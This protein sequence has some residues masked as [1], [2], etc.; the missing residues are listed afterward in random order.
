MKHSGDA[1][2]WKYELITGGMEMWG[3]GADP[4]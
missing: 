1:I 3:R 4:I 2:V